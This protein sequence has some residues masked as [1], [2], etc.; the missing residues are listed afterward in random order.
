MISA[1]FKYH[2]AYLCSA[3][4]FFILLWRH[5]P[6]G[7]RFN[8][9]QKV[10][11]FIV[12]FSQCFCLDRQLSHVRAVTTDDLL[13]DN[14]LAAKTFTVPDGE[15]VLHGVSFVMMSIWIENGNDQ[16]VPRELSVCLITC[17][18]KYGFVGVCVDAL[19]HSR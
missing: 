19:H 1:R 15:D 10:I 5:F 9:L 16:N 2:E 13:V 8:A 17:Y 11:A 18:G 7:N 3:L 14:A 4:S 12:F 6:H